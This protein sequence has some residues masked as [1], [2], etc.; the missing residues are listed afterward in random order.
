[1]N[2]EL[3]T[4]FAAVM[5]N[6]PVMNSRCN[7]SFDCAGCRFAVKSSFLSTRDK[8]LEGKGGSWFKQ[9]YSCPIQRPA[10]VERHSKKVSVS[11]EILYSVRTLL[12]RRFEE[13]FIVK[14]N[15]GGPL[16]IVPPVSSIS[17]SLISMFR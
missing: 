10:G 15:F 14:G 12:Q 11:M 4:L 2:F 6:R 17:I 16:S 8:Y 9:L 7:A 1:M 3:G 5:V 13:V